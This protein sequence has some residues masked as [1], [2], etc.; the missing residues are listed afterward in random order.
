MWLAQLQENKI[1]KV[2]SV[3]VVIVSLSVL[4]RLLLVIISPYNAT[5][6]RFV[7]SFN[8]NGANLHANLGLA[9]HQKG[10]LEEARVH[11]QKAISLDP[12]LYPFSKIMQ[13]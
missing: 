5:V 11:Y 4:I 9:L 10:T 13:Q 1:V 7:L 2:V 6:A 3:G 8:P 12:K